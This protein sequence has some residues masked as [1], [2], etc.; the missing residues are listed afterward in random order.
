MD[1]DYKLTWRKGQSERKLLN[2]L[3]SKVHTASLN[4]FSLLNYFVKSDY[5]YIVDKKCSSIFNA[6]Q[7][8]PPH[9]DIALQ[10]RN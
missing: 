8:P 9:T 5:I 3:N 2:Q 6:A 10:I 7:L 4:Y 1:T